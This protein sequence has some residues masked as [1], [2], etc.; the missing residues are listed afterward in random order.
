MIFVCVDSPQ[1]TALRVASRVHDGGHRVPPDKIAARYERMRG[2]VKAALPFVDFAIL[3]DNSSIENPHRPVAATA[4]GRIILRNPP[5]PW[6]AGE[7]LQD[8]PD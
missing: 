8:L 6:W 7:V 5:L 4:R 2:N 3:V 1:L